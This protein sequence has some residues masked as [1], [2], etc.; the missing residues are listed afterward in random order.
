MDQNLGSTTGALNK[1]FLEYG[2]VQGGS[3]YFYFMDH[4]ESIREM[5][6]M[7]GNIQAQNHF[8]PYGR[9]DYFQNLV[10]PE[11]LFQGYYL[12]KASGFS[13]TP[14]RTYS[15]ELG[16]WMSRDPVEETSGTN[17]YSFVNNSP[18]ILRD[19][20]GL[21]AI[22]SYPP[23]GSIH[24]PLDEKCWE[25]CKGKLP[26]IGPFLILSGIPILP[27][28]TKMKAT[29]GTSI[30]SAILRS[31]P[32]PPGMSYDVPP[33]ATVACPKT[34]SLGGAIARWLPWSGTFLTCYDNYKFICCFRNCHKSKGK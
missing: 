9:I 13:L 28:E 12:H 20:S 27:T 19:P 18:V 30:A 32:G 14:N 4:M 25:K 23:V 10:E 3:N 5:T 2:E 6:T 26:I 7:S 16:R 33:T 24:T 1:K 21:E 34:P 11:Y 8:D 15:S 29:W 31:F 17:L 22:Y